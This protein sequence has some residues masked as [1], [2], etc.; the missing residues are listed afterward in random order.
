[1]PRLIVSLL[2]LILLGALPAQA[3][4]KGS[5]S[6]LGFVVRLVGDRGCSGVVV[7]R[8]F[9]ATAAHCAEGMRVIAAGRSFRVTRISRSVVLDDGR[10]LTVSGDAAILRLATPLPAE[11]EIA[12]IGDGEGDSYT[13]VGYGTTDERW[14]VPS[15][16]LQE[17]TLVAQ[18]PGT[19]VDPNRT[20][21]IG[22]S[23]CFGDSGG[24]VLRGGMLVGIMARGSN[25][26]SS[27]SCGYLTHWEPLTL[28]APAVA[29]AEPVVSERAGAEKPRDD[30]PQRSTP[31]PR[32]RLNVGGTFNLFGFYVRR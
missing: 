6:A 3:V 31:R 23:V 15:R 32:M 11:V 2:V 7:A 26:G 20:S 29:S 9:V 13:I 16:L 21:R 8:D 30:Q 12:P 27:R 10:R 25:P 28:S 24:A 1:M 5:A 18:S 19:L 22:A 17:A 4:V 14:R